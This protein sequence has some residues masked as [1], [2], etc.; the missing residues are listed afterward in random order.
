MLGA[1]GKASDSGIS[2]FAPRSQQFCRLHMKPSSNSYIP[3]LRYVWLTRFY[4]LVVRLTT[5]ET[6][7]KRALLQQGGLQDGHRILDLGCGTGTLA[8][9][10]K[11]AHG[12]AEV[13]GLDADTVALNLARKKLEAAGVE[14]RLDQGLASTLP[15]RAE[16]FDR[17]LS[18]LFFHHL[19]SIVKLEVMREVLRVL[20]PGGEVHIADWGKPTNPLMRLAFVGVQLLDGFVTTA[21]NVHGRLPD[22]L[23]LAGFE[24]VETANCFS[25]PLGTISLYRA[26][27]P[28]A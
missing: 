28:T 15:Y 3:A 17:V 21:D 24:K 23:G 18:S 1:S 20:V 25:S 10:V 26:R 13:F 27:R 22:L 6:T 4:D 7:F 5:R 16:S 12:G 2:R 9:L 14:V 19:S 11:R 8:L